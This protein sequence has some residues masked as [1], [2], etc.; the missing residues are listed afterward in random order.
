MTGAVQR[1]LVDNRLGDQRTTGKVAQRNT[2]NANMLSWLQ[3]NAPELVDPVFNTPRGTVAL[4]V[5]RPGGP[6][7]WA[8]WGGWGVEGT[9][10]EAG[11]GWARRRPTQAVCTD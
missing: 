11:V 4:E 9:G 8:W 2:V 6:K 1:L 5:G 7:R 3:A 10:A